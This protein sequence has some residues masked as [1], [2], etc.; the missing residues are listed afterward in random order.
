M[1]NS[2]FIDCSFGISGDM[3][4][5]SLIDLGADIDYVRNKIASLPGIDKFSLAVESKN[6]HGIMTKELKLNFL[7]RNTDAINQ[8]EH[9]HRTNKDIIQ[10]IEDSELQEREKKRS[11]SIFNAIAHA[12]AKIHGLLVSEVHFHEVGAMDSIID[13]VG[14]CVALESLN[15]G[16]I[17]ANK[18]PTGHGYINIAHGLYPVPAPATMEI[19]KGLPLSEFTAEGELT[20]PTGAGFLKAL[21]DELSDSINGE[22]VNIGYGKGTKEFKH[23]NILR[24]MI[25]KEKVDNSEL[26]NTIECQIDDCTP[27]ELGYLFEILTNN[28]K[29]L[30]VYFTNVM[31]KKNRLG[32]LVTVLAYP[33]NTEEIEK[34]L[35]TQ[36]T[37]FG[38]RKNEYKR[39]VLDRS[40]EN[41]EVYG[42]TIK[43]KLAKLDDELL[44]AIPEY[45]DIKSVA[46]KTGVPVR[47]VYED[48]VV[49]YKQIDFKGE[50]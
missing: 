18:V 11:I 1:S 22:I 3:M 49:K 19:L 46:M 24:T 26:V 37:T 41:I 5:S 15:I 38:V 2:L 32:T 33:Q 28:K 25:L 30:D 39:V 13:I 29:V 7:N 10:M 40:F 45:E 21:V 4:L 12:E 20:T 42:E 8:H 34:L 44:K 35:L 14:T 27:E 16:K 43:M 50:S 17:I 48:I 6:E 23:P 31:M 36:S 9:H 47:T